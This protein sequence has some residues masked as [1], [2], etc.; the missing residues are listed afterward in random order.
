VKQPVLAQ[1]PEGSLPRSMRAP[2]Q[3]IVELSMPPLRQD[4][5]ARRRASVAG[6][7]RLS[8]TASARQA[9]APGRL[10]RARRHPH[11][12]AGSAADVEAPRPQV[13]PEGMAGSS[14]STPSN[15]SSWL[16]VSPPK[17]QQVENR[18]GMQ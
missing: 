13:E 16:E 3:A 8:S 2:R 9:G 11:Q 15:R 4:R 17:H 5:G 6:P 12:G 7:I 10:G 1:R 14:S 18:L